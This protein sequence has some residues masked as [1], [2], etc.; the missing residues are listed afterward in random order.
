MALQHP[1]NEFIDTLNESQQ[2]S[3]FGNGPLV[4]IGGADLQTLDSADKTRNSMHP[5]TLVHQAPP[6]I[7][8]FKRPFG[9]SGFKNV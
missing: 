2:S 3:M 4:N 6:K 5:K 1:H 8:K 7:A 9:I